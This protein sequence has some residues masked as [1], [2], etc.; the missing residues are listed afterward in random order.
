[1]AAKPLN[2]DEG[3]TI[4][5]PATNTTAF[6]KGGMCIYTSGLL[7]VA[8]A[9]GNVPIRLVVAETVTTTSSGQLVKCWPTEGVLYEVDTDDAWSTVDQGTLCDVATVST[10]NPDASTDDLFFIV[11]GVGTAEGTG[12]NL[13]VIGYFSQANET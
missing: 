13:K 11:K 7:D 9:G 3:K 1:M 12:K 8:V 10:L 4:L 5:V 2:W 6:V